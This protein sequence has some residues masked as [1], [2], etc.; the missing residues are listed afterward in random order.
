[1]NKFS[2]ALGQ[3]VV[4][5]GLLLGTAACSDDNVSENHGRPSTDIDRSGEQL[6]Q[7]TSDTSGSYKLYYHSEGGRKSFLSHTF[8][9]YS[10]LQDCEKERDV[11]IERL[12]QREQARMNGIHSP[13]EISKHAPRLDP[14]QKAIDK[15][16]PKVKCERAGQ[17]GP[18]PSGGG[19]L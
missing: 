14:S 16:T 8:G 4:G 12:A 11:Q 17:M 15:V 6:A 3:S 19:F 5:V 7:N 9:E 1:M 2:K 18:K 13:M 10:N